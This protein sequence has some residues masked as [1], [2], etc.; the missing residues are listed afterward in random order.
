MRK[1]ESYIDE[2]KTR[3]PYG[4]FLRHSLLAAPWPA[5]LRFAEVSREDLKGK[6]SELASVPR[7]YFMDIL[8]YQAFL[9]G[10]A[11]NNWSSQEKREH[12]YRVSEHFMAD[13]IIRQ[14][15]V[16]SPR[17]LAANQRLHLYS[18][19]TRHDVD[20]LMDRRKQIRAAPAFSSWIIAD[21]QYG[22]VSRE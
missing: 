13:I 22:L 11:S 16:T 1:Y 10:R 12:G 21:G 15:G 19:S 8:F 4:N 18:G 5:L 17:V 6:T 7:Q 9:I 20:T 2:D 3:E 14:Y